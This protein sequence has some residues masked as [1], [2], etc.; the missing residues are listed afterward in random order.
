MFRI[1]YSL[2]ASAQFLPSTLSS[3]SL[4]HSSA[5]SSLLFIPYIV[6]F[7]WLLNSSALSV[8]FLYFLSL[9]EVL[10][11]ILSSIIQVSEHL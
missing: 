7:V 11:E 2:W 3:S 5:S 4:L 10:A 9:V 1:I 8:S 6:F